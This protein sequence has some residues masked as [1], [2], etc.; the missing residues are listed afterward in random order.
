MRGHEAGG[1]AAAD[2]LDGAGRPKAGGHGGA[3]AVI[4]RGV[5]RAAAVEFL[6]Y[7]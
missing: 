3:D 4:C 7:G 1:L 6:L 2:H 5:D